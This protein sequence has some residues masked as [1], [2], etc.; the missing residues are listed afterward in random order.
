MICISGLTLFGKSINILL[1]TFFPLSDII[2]DGIHKNFKVMFPVYG[3]RLTIVRP[4]GKQISYTC[5]VDKLRSPFI[6]WAAVL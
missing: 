1:L 2:L 3:F 5:F 4:F 6:T